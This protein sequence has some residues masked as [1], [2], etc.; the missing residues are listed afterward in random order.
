MKVGGKPHFGI[1][2]AGIENS[3]GNTSGRDREWE[4][5][6]EITINLDR[7]PNS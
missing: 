5:P 3:R 1:G 6:G 4:D 7:H 2:F